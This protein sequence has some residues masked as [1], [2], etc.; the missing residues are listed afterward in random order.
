MGRTEPVD[1]AMTIEGASKGQIVQ[2]KRVPS[3]GWLGA[4][5]HFTNLSMI[6]DGLVRTSFGSQVGNFFKNFWVLLSNFDEGSC[7]STAKTSRSSER[8]VAAEHW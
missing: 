7:S 4:A 2:P 3:S 8:A 6:D 1:T 5:N